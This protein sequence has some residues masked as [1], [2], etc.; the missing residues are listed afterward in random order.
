MRL[1]AR[2]VSSADASD[3]I[4]DSGNTSSVTRSKSWLGA[5]TVIS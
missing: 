5:K 4:D 3:I 2:I 1:A